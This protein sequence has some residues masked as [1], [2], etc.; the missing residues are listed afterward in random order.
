MRNKES[1]KALILSIHKSR[2][3]HAIQLTIERNLSDHTLSDV[4]RSDLQQMAQIKSLDVLHV[5]TAERLGL[6]EEAARLKAT[7][8][9]RAVQVD[10][11]KA[12]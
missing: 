3:L 2:S 8:R 5:F 9:Q 12:A 10:Q 7:L 4:Q 11:R 1:F 6:T